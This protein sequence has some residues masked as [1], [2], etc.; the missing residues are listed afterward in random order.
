MDPKMSADDRHSEHAEARTAKK[1]NT[2]RAEWIAP[3]L[4][5]LDISRTESGSGAAVT[6]TIW[7]HS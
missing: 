1:G 3:Q 5:E 2:E 4:T 7:Y 6:E